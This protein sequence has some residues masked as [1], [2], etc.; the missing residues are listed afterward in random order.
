MSVDHYDD[1]FII[2]VSDKGIGIPKEKLISVTEPFSRHVADPHKAYNGI[3]LGL[4]ITKSLV[5]Q[6]DGELS[7]ES[8]LGQGTTVTVLLPGKA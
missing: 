7:I 2:K 6:H 8:E 4:A 1:F 3:G 5:V